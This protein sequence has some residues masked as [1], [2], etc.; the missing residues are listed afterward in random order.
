MVPRRGAA[1]DPGPAR[2][3]A[4]SALRGQRRAPPYAGSGRALPCTRPCA[5]SARGA[6]PSGL[7]FIACGRDGVRSFLRLINGQPAKRTAGW[8]FYVFVIF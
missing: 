4:G 2:A 7:P 5:G 1:P 8:P 6:N 3:A